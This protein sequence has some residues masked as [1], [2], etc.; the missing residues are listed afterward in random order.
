MMTASRGQVLNWTQL[1]RT[2]ELNT[3]EHSNLIRRRIVE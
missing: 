2:V 1:F 3:E